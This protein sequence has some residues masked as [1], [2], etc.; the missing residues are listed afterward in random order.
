MKIGTKVRYKGITGTVIFSFTQD[1]I[2]FND[3]QLDNGSRKNNKYNHELEIIQ[4][5]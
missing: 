1:N 5:E 4:N 2:D 3:I